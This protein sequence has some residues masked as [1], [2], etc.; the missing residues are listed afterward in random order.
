[1]RWCTAVSRCPPFTTARA[2]DGI[3]ILNAVGVFGTT[4]R[5]ARCPVALSRRRDRR[6][7]RNASAV[8]LASPSLD[9]GLLLLEL[10]SPRRRSNSAMRAAWTAI[11]V[12]NSAIMESQSARAAVR[13]ETRWANVSRSSI[14]PDTSACPVCCL[15]PRLQPS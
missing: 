3:M 12:R 7:C 6:R 9:G 5:A 11:V 13:P 8:G 4:E 10:S 15:S 2:R 1:M 14:I